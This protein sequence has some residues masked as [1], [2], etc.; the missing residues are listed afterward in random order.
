MRDKTEGRVGDICHVLGG[1]QLFIRA[2]SY[3]N[4]QQFLSPNGYVPRSRDPGRKWT[5][6]EEA[7]L[8][9]NSMK[10]VTSAWL[11]A[12]FPF[13]GRSLNSIIGH[14]A[15]MRLHGRLS[16]KWRSK[17][18]NDEPP[19]TLREDIEIMQWH[20]WGREHIDPQIFVDNQRAG[21]SVIAR[22]DYLCKDPELVRKV[23]EAE[24]AARQALEARD[25]A[26]YDAAE[27]PSEETMDASAL[28]MMN[29][30]LFR[31]ESD[32]I[33]KICDAISQSLSNREDFEDDDDEEDEE[34]EEEVEAE[35]E[36]DAA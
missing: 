12:N 32:T 19:Y 2:L 34:G 28:R 17:T 18:W 21:G 22:A 30:I 13:A 29:R 24:E 25:E 5:D 26:W 4:N 36:E 35:D 33:V 23:K 10:D 11:H 3:P 15:D 8:V 7:W 9:V 16:R 6:N 20:V 27:E 1:L 31:T 14:L